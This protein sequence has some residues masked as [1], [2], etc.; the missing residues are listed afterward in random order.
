VEMVF[1]EVLTPPHF[2]LLTV[3]KKN[4]YMT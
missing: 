4:N 1:G 3:Y 2:L